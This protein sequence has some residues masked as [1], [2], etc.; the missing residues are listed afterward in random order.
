MEGGTESDKVDIWEALRGQKSP[1]TNSSTSPNL[2]PN[3][4]SEED[5]QMQRFVQFL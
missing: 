3:M 1:S 2:H 4:F 5:T